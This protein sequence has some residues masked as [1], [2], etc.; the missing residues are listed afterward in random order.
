MDH[1]L[2]GQMTKCFL[3]AK[4]Q[5]QP[6][7]IYSRSVYEDEATLLSIV[8]GGCTKDQLLSMI[9]G[10]PHKRRMNELLDLIVP[11]PMDLDIY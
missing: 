8:Y 1:L 4:Q 6:N 3:L 11:D 10:Y 2:K 7:E 9:E 5:K